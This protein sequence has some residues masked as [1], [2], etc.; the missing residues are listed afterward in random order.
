MSIDLDGEL[1]HYNKF[2]WHPSET[3]LA[4]KFKNE[5]SLL[6]KPLSTNSSVPGNIHSPEYL[7]FWI[8]VLKV[9]ENFVR[10]LKDGYAL[11]FKNGIPPPSVFSKNNKSFMEKK[12]FGIEEI[13]RLEKLGCIYK[14]DVQPTIVLPLSV[15]HSGKWRLVVDVSRHLNQYLEE[16]HVK[17]E[18]LDDAELSVEQGDYQA[19]S[20]LDSGYWHE[21][22]LCLVKPWAGKPN[23]SNNFLLSC[24]QVL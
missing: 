23:L 20:D 17:L 3:H 14:V 21:S 5:S 13:E 16:R 12:Q 22:S 2:V 4:H 9:D 24:K 10:F 8:Q 18:T 15:V 19:I 1:A 11:P 7:D 6:D